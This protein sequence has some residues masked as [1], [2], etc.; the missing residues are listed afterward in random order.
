M[1]VAQSIATSAANMPK[2]P[3]PKGAE[4]QGQ[5][6]GQ[7]SQ[8]QGQGQGQGQQPAARTCCSRVDEETWW[9]K[10]LCCLSLP[11]RVYIM[12]WETLSVEDLWFRRK[13]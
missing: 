6:Q 1:L 12:Y 8:S 9:G 7:Q 10:V 2:Q 3:K 5:G 13:T 11:I 4:E